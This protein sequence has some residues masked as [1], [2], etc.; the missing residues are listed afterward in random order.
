MISRYL[1]TSKWQSALLTI[2]HKNCALLTIT[3]KN[4]NVNGFKFKIFRG[5]GGKNYWNNWRCHPG[6]HKKATT[7]SVSIFNGDLSKIE[8]FASFL[9]NSRSLLCVALSKMFVS[10]SKC[11]MKMSFN[12]MFSPFKLEWLQL[13]YPRENLESLNILNIEYSCFH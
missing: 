3:H 12:S 7:W 2:T 6:K 10:G 13:R 9:G 8:L 11:W 1:A 5:W 4:F